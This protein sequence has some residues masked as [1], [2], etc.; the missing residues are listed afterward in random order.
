MPPMC[1]RRKE[2]GAFVAQSGAGAE[3]HQGGGEPAYEQRQGRVHVGGG[4]EEP[5]HVDR[6]VEQQRDQQVSPP[7]AGPEPDRQPEHRAYL[8]RRHLPIR[9]ALAVLLA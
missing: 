9:G 8:K 6:R 1:R 2:G 3:D 7:L 4:Q 5:G